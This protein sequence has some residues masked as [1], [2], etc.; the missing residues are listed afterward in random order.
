[1]DKRHFFLQLTAIEAE[2]VEEAFGEYAHKLWW[3]PA[4]GRTKDF[5]AIRRAQKKLLASRRQK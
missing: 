1:M 4:P 2:A 3:E 5:C